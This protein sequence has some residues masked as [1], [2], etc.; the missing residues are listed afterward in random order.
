M[1][2][3]INIG[4]FLICASLILNGYFLLFDEKMKTNFRENFEI[5]FSMH[6]SLKQILIFNLTDKIR[7]ALAGFQIFSIILLVDLNN[8]V[9]FLNIFSII[10]FSVI[11]HNPLIMKIKNK[12]KNED[13]YIILQNLAIIGSLLSF[14]NFFPKIKET[15]KKAKNNKTNKKNLKE[16]ID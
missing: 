14:S 3:F 6:S 9:I 1:N 10:M 8:F 7:M 4:K 11:N 5:V 13:F 16:K 2:F 12:Y 15:A